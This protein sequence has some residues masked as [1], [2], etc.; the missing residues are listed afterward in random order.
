MDAGQLNL[1]LRIAVCAWCKPRKADGS[2]GAVSH[3]IC[4]R[5]LQKF[6]QESEG[7]PPRRRRR[8]PARSVPDKTS[9]EAQLPF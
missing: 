5:H 7:I 6:K 8:G 3:G 9:G 2:L 4:P 1:S